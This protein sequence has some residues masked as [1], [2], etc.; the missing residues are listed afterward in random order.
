MSRNKNKREETN[1]TKF[2]SC[3]QEQKQ[4]FDKIKRKAVEE[5]MILEDMIHN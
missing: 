5:I 1:K 2:S 4:I 3:D